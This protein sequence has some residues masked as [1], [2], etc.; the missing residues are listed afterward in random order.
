MKTFEEIWNEVQPLNEVL[1][2]ISTGKINV[3]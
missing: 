3:K 2:F 1:K